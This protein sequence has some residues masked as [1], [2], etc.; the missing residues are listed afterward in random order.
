MIVP[1]ESRFSALLYCAEKG[2]GLRAGVAAD[3]AQPIR[4]RG[5]RGVRSRRPP[6]LTIRSRRLP[7]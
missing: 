7:L 4:S 6:L 3:E 2:E 1:G 5:E